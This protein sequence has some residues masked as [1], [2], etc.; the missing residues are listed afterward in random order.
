M[1]TLTCLIIALGILSTILIQK[2]KAMDYGFIPYLI[3]CLFAAFL[4]IGIVHTLVVN[5][6]LYCP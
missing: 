6:I 1:I 2:G 5:I 3:I 4:W